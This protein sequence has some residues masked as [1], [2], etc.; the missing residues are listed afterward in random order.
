MA[1][2]CLVLLFA[3]VV[4]FYRFKRTSAHKAFLLAPIPLDPRMKQRLAA[5]VGFTET[6]PAAVST[7]DVLYH[8]WGPLQHQN[9]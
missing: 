9:H 5:T 7:F 2:L 1:L 8:R 3:A 4:V 6:I